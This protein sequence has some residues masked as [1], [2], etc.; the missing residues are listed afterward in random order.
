MART[1]GAIAASFVLLS[2]GG[3]LIHNFWL[4]PDYQAHSEL[5]RSQNAMQHRLPHLYIANLL[6]SIAAVL[7]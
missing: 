5:W 1:I 6:Y 4:M 7:I 3:F 2:L